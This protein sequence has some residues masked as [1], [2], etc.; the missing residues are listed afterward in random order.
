[1]NIRYE[2]S[3]NQ[4][5]K[6][7]GL[8]DKLAGRPLFTSNRNIFWKTYIKKKYDL[9]YVGMETLSGKHYLEGEEHNITWFLLNL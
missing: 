5:Y 4:L 9:T 2:L 1:M 7:D 8:C 3:L 6:I